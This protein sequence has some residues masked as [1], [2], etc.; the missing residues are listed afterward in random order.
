MALL[1]IV[2][3]AGVGWVGW[4]FVSC[5]RTHPPVLERKAK[6]EAA[7]LER[8]LAS[9]TDFPSPE[10]LVE[11]ISKEIIAQYPKPQPAILECIGRLVHSL[12]RTEF[13]LTNKAPETFNSDEGVQYREYLNKQIAKRT[14]LTAYRA[15][16]AALTESIFG[17]VKHL[18]SVT[19]ELK[20]AQALCFDI[21]VKTVIDDVRP[22]IDG[23]AS[24]F[25]SEACK[26]AGTAESLRRAF[27]N[28]W[29]AVSRRVLTK[30]AIENGEFVDPEKHPGNP[31]EVLRD[32]LQGTP[33][34]S[35]F[36]GEFRF[37]FPEPQRLEHA[38]IIAGSGHG[39]SQFLEHLIVN[40][41]VKDDPPGIVLIDSK[42]D[43]V[44]RL[45]KIE[46]FHP[47]EGRLK[48][49]II[50]LDPRDRPALNLFDVN[51]DEIGRYDEVYREQVTNG[52]VSTYEYFFGSLLGAELTSKMSVIFRPLVELMIRI[53]GADIHTL[54]GAM[55]DI[56]PYAEIIETLPKGIRLFLQ[57]EFRD[58]SYAETK[59]QVKRRLYQMVQSETFDRMFSA[60]K[61][62]ID[63]AAALNQGKIIL[64]NADKPYLQDYSAVFGRYF[65]A[66]TINAA[67]RRAVIP[68][69]KRKIVHLYIDEAAAYFDQKTDELLTT[70]RSYKLGATFAF[71]YL[72]QASE[73]LRASMNVNTSIKLM[74][75][76]EGDAKT[77]AEPMRT[78][79]QFIQQFKKDGRDPPRYS[80]FACYIRNAIP[81]AIGIGIR[82][83][84][85]D[86]FG[87]M[88]D[89]TYAE[90]RHGNRLYVSGQLSSGGP[91]HGADPTRQP[92][93]DH[94]SSGETAEPL[95][96]LHHPDLPWQLEENDVPRNGQQGEKT[97]KG[98]EAVDTKPARQPA[99]DQASRGK[100][101]EP[102]LNLHRPDLPWQ[103][104]K[105]GAP[106]SSNRKADKTDKNEE[107]ADTK[108]ADW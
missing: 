42:G 3:F 99:P 70:L 52:V 104:E 18:P 10:T 30:S 105:N 61:N 25:F 2:F 43:I 65:I 100:P 49:R 26:A 45:A 48:D 34:L 44:E 9:L 24:P 75:G 35:L 95:L 80:E 107:D 57:N 60:A 41:L 88:D 69:A 20:N 14:N 7:S 81:R 71:Q 6:A 84:V 38:V 19:N 93:S 101:A 8:Q 32:Y 1:W 106:K 22:V 97:E 79:P 78:T 5:Y 91:R 67:H 74:G 87:K 59:T 73:A 63:F 51:F 89:A 108:P 76:V 31:E 102:L 64:I 66:L 15:F 13:E 58:K 68:E 55:D 12:Y 23:L 47:T 62:Q 98:K 29:D 39:K 21:Q 16:E 56:T 17:Y 82:F 54:I 90:M 86:Q 37:E 46:V 28:N 83:G 11:H 96:N 92:A 36:E 40:D 50:V 53:P 72:G 33:F 94:A 77:F 103:L 27:S 85:L 4:C